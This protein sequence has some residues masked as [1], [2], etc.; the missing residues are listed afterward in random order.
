VEDQISQQGVWPIFLLVNGGRRRLALRLCEAFPQGLKRLRQPGIKQTP[1]LTLMPRRAFKQHLQV[2][3][4]HGV[5]AIRAC[6]A[7]LGQLSAKIQ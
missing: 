1:D 7:Q 4:G 5:V 3:A 2:M 6:Q